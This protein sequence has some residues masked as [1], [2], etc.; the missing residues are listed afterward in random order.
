MSKNDRFTELGICN[1]SE[2]VHI[3]EKEN[4]ELRSKL[5]EKEVE[6]NILKKYFE[7]SL[8]NIIANSQRQNSSPLPYQPI[9]DHRPITPIQ[10]PQPNDFN[11]IWTTNPDSIRYVNYPCITTSDRPLM[12][13]QENENCIHRSGY[14]QFMGNSNNVP[15]DNE[16]NN[17]EPT[18]YNIYS[19][20]HNHIYGQ[21]CS[22]L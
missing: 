2:R 9:Q 13:S 17:N 15:S 3:L 5:M 4:E 11:P 6:L 10:N 14:L 1:D 20:N 22:V 12:Y 16:V 19:S 8:A 7:E 21:N 18:I